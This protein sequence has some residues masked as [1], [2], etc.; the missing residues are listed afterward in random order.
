MKYRKA[1]NGPP[2]HLE[3]SLSQVLNISHRKHF[4]E[5]TRQPPDFYIYVSWVYRKFFFENNH[6]KKCL[7]VRENW[8]DW[9]VVRSGK[10]SMIVKFI[11][12][13]LPMFNICIQFS[14]C[15]IVFSETSSKYFTRIFLI[16]NAIYLMLF[17]SKDLNFSSFTLY[18]ES[19]GKS[20]KIKLG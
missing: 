10:I 11:L 16:V 18:A 3:P 20:K 19:S 5:N 9:D 2:F 15:C 14:N 12:I 8:Y 17:F 4:R 6:H 13:I 7:K 1:A